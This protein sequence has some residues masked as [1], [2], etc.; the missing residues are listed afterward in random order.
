MSLLRKLKRG[1]CKCIFGGGPEI[2][3]NMNQVAKSISI[4]VHPSS[5]IPACLFHQIV[6]ITIRLG[7]T[8][9]TNISKD[10]QKSLKDITILL[11]TLLRGTH[12]NKY[13]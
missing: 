9:E 4:D 10:H 7:Y 11:V 1:N 12:P 8:T 2:S 13:G 6:Q 3:I 5:K